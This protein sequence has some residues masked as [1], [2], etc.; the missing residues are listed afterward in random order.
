M[1]ETLIHRGHVSAVKRLFAFLISLVGHAVVLTVFV[2]IPLV[3]LNVLPEMDVLAFLLAPPSAPVPA[4]PPPPVPVQRAA[5]PTIARIGIEMV[6]PDTM[7]TTIPPPDEEPTVATS[8]AALFQITGGTPGMDGQRAAMAPEW[9]KPPL[10]EAPPAPKPV[11]RKP[12]LVVAKLQEAK[13]IQ[14]V[15]PIYP[16][17]AIKARITGRVILQVTVDEDGNV[18]SIQVLQGHP[19][20]EGAAV[21]AVK[22]WKYAPTILNG[23]PVPVTANVTVIFVLR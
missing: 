22:Q 12:L 20:L 23:E 10:P 18:A 14:K 6:Q 9:I 16:E 3:Y 15:E 13:L 4:P 11:Q 1:F 5:A 7:P 21:S 8:L 17:L 19:L 2:I